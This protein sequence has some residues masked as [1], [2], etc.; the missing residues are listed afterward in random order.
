MHKK[1]SF[2]YGAHMSIAGEPA[3]AIE[4]G[5]SIGCTAIQIFTK[6]NRQWHAK[7][8]TDKESENFKQT[9]KNSS[10]KSIIAHTSYLIN[11]GSPNKEL[12]HKSVHALGVEMERCTQLDI[13]YLVLHPGS[14]SN[15]DKEESLKRISTNLDHLF[16]QYPDCS[17]L[18]ETMAGQGTN[19]GNSFEQL[20]AIIKLSKH[21]RR[22]GVCLDTCHVFTAGYDLRDEK[23][24]DQMW[25]QFD[26]V[27]GLEKLKAI[28]VNDS[29]K[30]IGSCVDRHTDIGKG[31]IG[32]KAFELLCNDPKLFDVP[33]ILETPK[34]DLA[35]D[36]RNMDVLLD[37]LDKKTRKLL[38]VE[39]K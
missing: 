25:K 35:D 33:K 32:L 27:I 6:S 29:K 16:D 8:I 4:R 13:P 28:H 26:K 37:L 36:K 24:Y 19:I 23:S 18:L 30:E 21:K 14:H 7:P 22:L 5:E 17:I 10:I 38:H 34:D 9:W 15:T 2:L 11:I 1:H 39:E 20:A 12:E 3:K 31:K